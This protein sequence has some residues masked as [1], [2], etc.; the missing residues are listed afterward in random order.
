[1]KLTHPL[2]QS[3]KQVAFQGV[4]VLIG[5][6]EGNVAGEQ[7]TRVYNWYLTQDLCTVVFLDARTGR[8]YTARGLDL[9][10]FQPTKVYY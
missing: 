4:A 3:H 9:E 10:G 7:D 1:M 8:E 5:I 6:V 2:D